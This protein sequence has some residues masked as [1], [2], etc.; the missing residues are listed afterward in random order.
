M[1][2]WLRSE[3]LSVEVGR[4]PA[5][6]APAP[7]PSLLGAADVDLSSLLSGSKAGGAKRAKQV[8]ESVYCIRSVVRVTVG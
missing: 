7:P 1:V 6:R 8:S 2:D 5:A 4:Q 3:P